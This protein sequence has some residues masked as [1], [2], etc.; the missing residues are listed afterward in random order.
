MDAP[1]KNLFDLAA[2]QFEKGSRAIG[3]SKDL[4]T[5][6]SQPKNEIIIHLPVR[7]ASGEVKLFKGYRVQHNNVC[8]PFKGGMRYHQDVT[9]DECKA[10]ADRHGDRF[11]PPANLD[12]LAQ[13]A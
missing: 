11:A 9:L 10:L 5:L 7:L 1:P 13:A 3:L 2:A 4:A 8:G 6:L 12:A